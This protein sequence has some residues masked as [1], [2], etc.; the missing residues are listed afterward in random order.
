MGWDV[1]SIERMDWEMLN[2]LGSL[3]MVNQAQG[4]VAA[5]NTIPRGTQSV[6]C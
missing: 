6:G 5:T 1:L 4:T 3:E 2:M